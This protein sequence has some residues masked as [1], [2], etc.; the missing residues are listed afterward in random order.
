MTAQDVQSCAPRNRPVFI[1]GIQ[2]LVP[3]LCP[4]RGCTLSA[5]VLDF[6]QT[7]R[8]ASVLEHACRP[9]PLTRYER[10]GELPQG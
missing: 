7:K 9:N 4:R 1:E 10:A 2:V 3:G 5:D 8:P 6:L